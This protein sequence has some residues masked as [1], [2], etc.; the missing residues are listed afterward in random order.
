[1]SRCCYTRLCECVQLHIAQ[2]REIERDYREIEIS[3]RDNYISIQLRYSSY[4]GVDLR[5]RRR[6]GSSTFLRLSRFFRSCKTVW[7]LDWYLTKLSNPFLGLP[8]TMTLWITRFAEKSP[9]STC[10]D[11][12]LDDVSLFVSVNTWG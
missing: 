7:F 3:G 1:M 4:Q 5:G 10:P 8:I 11:A 9:D 2:Q 12:R 6:S